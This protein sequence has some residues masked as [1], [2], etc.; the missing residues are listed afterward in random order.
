MVMEPS[1]RAWTTGMDSIPNISAFLFAA[2]DERRLTAPFAMVI[3]P[4]RKKIVEETCIIF[5]S[6]SV[7]IVV[8]VCLVYIRLNILYPSLGGDLRLFD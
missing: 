2:G 7:L 8:S 6:L 4:W 5:S 3:I 1:A